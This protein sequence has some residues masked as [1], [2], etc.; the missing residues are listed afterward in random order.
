MLTYLGTDYGGHKVDLD[1]VPEG[2]NI[3]SAGLSGDISFD[4]QLIKRKRC[5]I[6][7]IGASNREAQSVEKWKQ[8]GIIDDNFIFYHR[9]L[10]GS[11]NKEISFYK[12]T[13]FAN[14]WAGMK[15]SLIKT[16]SLDYLFSIYNNISLVKIDIEGS[17]YSVINSLNHLNIS[18]LCIEFHHWVRGSNFTK[19]N[20][21]NCIERIK[22]F[23][24]KLVSNTHPTRRR[25]CFEL[26][27]IR[28]DLSNKYNDIKE[29]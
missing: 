8:Q 13:I 16:I 2:S 4:L 11:N 26:T 28:N 18:Q 10:Y 15:P 9:A 25:K 6:V 22:N 27:F 20:T 29:I 19:K 7:A 14:H 1:L 17:E 12:N 23:G 5:R 3:I 24:Y 21:I